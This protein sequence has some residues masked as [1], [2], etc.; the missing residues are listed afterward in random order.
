MKAQVAIEYMVIISVAFI[1][2]IPLIIYGNDLLRIYNDDARI[3]ITRNTVDK[4]GKGID[5]VYSQGKPAKLSS[6]IFIPEGITNVSIENKTIILKIKTSGGISDIYYTTV[7]S[8]N[9]SLPI[10]NGYY[11]VS[12]ISYGNY[13]NISW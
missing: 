6:R 9:G 12:L 3:S 7:A 8:L 10:N 13:V 11:T 4:L 2:L 1:I 5:W